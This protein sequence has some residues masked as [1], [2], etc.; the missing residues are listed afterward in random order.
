MKVAVNLGERS[1]DVVIGSGVRHQLADIIAARAPRAKMAAVITSATVASLAW[2][3]V[4]TGLPTVI[5][6]VPD[7]D[8]AKTLAQLES[9]CIEL[10][11]AEF[12]RHDV[13]VGVGGGAVTD[14]AGFVAAS[15]LRG[16]PVI[17]VPTTLVGQ[18]D[19]A[20]GGKTA[21]NLTTG[22]NLV[23]A[24]HQPLAVLC[25]D[26][27]LATLSPREV[28]DGLGEVAKCSLLR[29]RRAEELETVGRTAL[30]HDAVVLKAEIVS[31]DEREGGRRALLN[32]G[33]TLAHAIEALE[34]AGRPLDVRHGEA[35]AIGCAFAARLARRMG[36]I[37]DA[38]VANHDATLAWFGLDATLPPGLPL[39]ELLAAMARDKKAHHELTFVL[40]GPNGPEVVSGVAPDLVRS[41]LESFGGAR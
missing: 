34:L 15:Y 16:V 38:G 25:D 23:G 40:D 17:H 29:R 28:T 8:S 39:D 6:T 30:I 21:V 13:I 14:L 9:V 18:V 37:D 24:F 31:E 12:S 41:E 10:S 35:V 32:Y 2:S 22:K 27:T 19:A 7:G 11:R 20:V 33:H 5:I 3:K 36:R 4:E 26:E 1:Y